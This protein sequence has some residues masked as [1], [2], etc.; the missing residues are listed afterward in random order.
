MSRKQDRTPARQPAD[1]GTRRRWRVTPLILFVIAAVLAIINVQMLASVWR[2][3]PAIQVAR[4]NWDA[5]RTARRDHSGDA[6]QGWILAV[7]SSHVPT[8]RRD[9]GRIHELIRD[10]R[11]ALAQLPSTDLGRLQVAC[12]TLMNLEQA[13]TPAAARWQRIAPYVG[14]LERGN[15][16]HLL[17]EIIT[18]EADIYERQGVDRG[19]AYR[20]AL[21][22]YGFSHG[23]FLQR[24]VQQMT[25][26]AADLRAA[27]DDEHAATCDRLAN[28][29]LRQWALDDGPLTLRMQAADLL[30]TRLE[31]LSTTTAPAVPTGLALSLREW[32]AAQRAKLAASVVP[33]A[34]LR[35]GELPVDP[36]IIRYATRIQ[37]SAVLLTSALI[38]ALCVALLTLFWAIRADGG[39]AVSV[40][41]LLSV[42]AAAILLPIGSCYFGD[43][44]TDF[45]YAEHTRCLRTDLGWPRTPLIACAATVLVLLLFGLLGALPRLRLSRVLN[46]IAW[47]AAASAVCLAVFGFIMTYAAADA[48]HQ[49]DSRLWQSA[50]KFVGV[51]VESPDPLLEPLRQ[52]RP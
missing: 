16:A 36:F 21:G 29:L 12:L 2:N 23:P 24:F 4:I 43:M 22:G 3:L 17:P 34:L 39:A 40:R 37:S 44:P 13:G 20:L 19:V 30:A 8:A 50:G 1:S 9:P 41:G 46:R 47:T 31:A 28:R 51:V 5:V 52:W 10:A 32:H 48:A 49:L 35:V 38:T 33:P 15:F 45:T 14:N 26:L 11:G 18:A 6:R 25:R 42:V 7:V 27:G